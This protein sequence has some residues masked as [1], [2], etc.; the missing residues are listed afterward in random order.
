[1]NAVHIHLLLNHVPVIGTFIAVLLLGY[2]LLRRSQALVRAGLGMLVLVALAAGVVYVTGEPAEELVEGL[3][4][5]SMPILERHEEAALVAVLLLG[6]AALF[7][8][9]ILLVFR[10]RESGIPWRFATAAFLF[11]LLPAAAMGYVANLGGQ[12]RH[13]E[14]RTEVIATPGEGADT[15]TST[16]ATAHREPRERE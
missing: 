9:A 15:A 5:T 10:R 12:I 1:M 3:A 7:A 11:A 14:I 16:A 13:P 2:A 8:F 6:L 4:G